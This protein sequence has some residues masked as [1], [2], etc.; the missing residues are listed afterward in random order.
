[1]QM[2]A[3]RK[4][5]KLAQ[6]C[7]KAFLAGNDLILIGDKFEEQVQVLEHFEKL[8]SDRKISEERLS[9]SLDKILL[10]KRK[11]KTETKS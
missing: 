9:L 6:A 8:V 1:M 7:Q 5:Q 2:G 4:N 10:A 3:I 11:L